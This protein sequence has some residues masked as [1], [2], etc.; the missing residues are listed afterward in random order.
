MRV[1][2]N[3]ENSSF[4]NIGVKE[5]VINKSECKLEIDQLK[6]FDVALKEANGI[7]LE[8]DV[9]VTDNLE[10]IFIASKDLTLSEAQAY[11]LLSNFFRN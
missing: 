11:F 5:I 2:S 4:S 9:F 10:D 7:N 3:G 1:I 8:I 6:L